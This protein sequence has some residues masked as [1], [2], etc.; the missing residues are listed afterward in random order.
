MQL[1]ASMCRDESNTCDQQ[2]RTTAWLCSWHSM[3]LK[4]WAL[5]F[6]L[7]F[8]SCL[9]WI[10]LNWAATLLTQSFISFSSSFV[11][12]VH[13]CQFI[14]WNTLIPTHSDDHGIGANFGKS[15]VTDC[16]IFFWAFS[17]T[18]ALSFICCVKWTTDNKNIICIKLGCLCLVNQCAIVSGTSCPECPWD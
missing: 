16:K 9:L 11:K 8:N 15:M 3:K 7:N 12:F 6:T 5:C 4:Q 13:D 2:C 17:E 10:W 18:S 1:C 14:V